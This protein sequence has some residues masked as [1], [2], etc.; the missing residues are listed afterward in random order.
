MGEAQEEII[1]NKGRPVANISPAIASCYL[2]IMGIGDILPNELMR[3]TKFHAG[4][5]IGPRKK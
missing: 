1:T 2:I 4:I 3:Y 5:F